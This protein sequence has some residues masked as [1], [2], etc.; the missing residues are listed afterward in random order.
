MTPDHLH[1]AIGLAGVIDVLSRVAPDT[2][3][4][5]PV[6]IEATNIYP[7]LTLNS[8]DNLIAR[9]PLTNVFGNLAPL[10]ECNFREASLT[11]DG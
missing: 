8:P 4:D 2:T 10:A 6:R 3:I 7:L 9:Y 5:A 11:I 1:K